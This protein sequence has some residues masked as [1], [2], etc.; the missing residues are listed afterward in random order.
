MMERFIISVEQKKDIYVSAKNKRDAK[1]KAKKII[2]EK[3]IK[4]FFKIN[5][6]EETF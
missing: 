2:A 3:S 1:K 4:K 6:V 5:Y